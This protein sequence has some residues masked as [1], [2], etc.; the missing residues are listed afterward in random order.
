[1]AIHIYTKEG[2]SEYN[3]DAYDD[4]YKAIKRANEHLQGTDTYFTLVNDS[5]IV[6]VGNV[7]KTN[8]FTALPNDKGVNAT[9]DKASVEVRENYG[10]LTRVAVRTNDGKE[11]D[12]R[13]PDAE[14]AGTEFNNGQYNIIISRK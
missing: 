5:V 14:I 11:V 6:T 12:L 3:Y 4:P 2:S 8:S 10:G 13:I 9:N 1:M 7:K